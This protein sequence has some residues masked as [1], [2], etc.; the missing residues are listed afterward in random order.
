MVNTCFDEVITSLRYDEYSHCIEVNVNQSLFARKTNFC[1]KMWPFRK[2][3]TNKEI[4]SNL[5]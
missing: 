1:K 5:S 2:V 4:E 3:N